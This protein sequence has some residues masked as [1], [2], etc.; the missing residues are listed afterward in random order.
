MPNLFGEVDA[1]DI[2]EDPFYVAP[3]TYDCMVTDATFV[4]RKDGQGHGLSIKYLITN[5]DS[6]FEGNT[7]QEW[8]NVYPDLSP[9]DIT[10]EI[11]RHLSFVKQRLSQLG[12]PASEMNGILDNLDS[13]VGIKC[14]VNVTETQAQDGSRTYTNVRNVYIPEDSDN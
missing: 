13:L 1:D 7:I 3:G 5:A 2:P 4:T 11:K 9:E 12:V 8:K 10:P 6:E 14:V